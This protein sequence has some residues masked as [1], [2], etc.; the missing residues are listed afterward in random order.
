MEINPRQV[1][2]DRGNR[3]GVALN[4]GDVFDLLH[5]IFEVGWS[6]DECDHACCVE[7]DPRDA[8]LFNKALT[9]DTGLAP[10]EE[11]SL[12]FTSLAC[13]H[14]NA[15]LRAVLAAVPSDDPLLSLDGRLSLQKI[16]EK[17]SE[18]ASAVRNGLRWRVYKTMCG[19]VTL[20][21]WLSSKAPETRDWIDPSTK[22]KGCSGCSRGLRMP[23]KEEFRQT[24]W[25]FAAQLYGA[26]QDGA[27]MW[28]I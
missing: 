5:D 25:P 28:T 15:G 21:R 7:A 13:G 8:E 10:I 17:D 18:M 9:E 4:V 12:R 16:E 1:G 3:D 26:S 6:W 22:S 24:G 19:F 11:D 23:L 20:K 14:T 27:H 2:F